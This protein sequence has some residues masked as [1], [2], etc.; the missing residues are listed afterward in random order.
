[1]K[2]VTGER[3]RQMGEWSSMR[4]EKRVLARGWLL[5]GR[6]CRRR[7]ER[8]GRRRRVGASIA[9]AHSTRVSARVVR[10]PLPLAR[11]ALLS[12]RVG[13][14][15]AAAAAAGVFLTAAAAA[16]ADFCS[17]LMATV[18]CGVDTR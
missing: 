14:P 4:G 6:V 7:E 10:P 13:V 2:G 16:G 1:M 18:L 9:I 15:S 17:S 3:D 11:L 12:S 8:A 5:V